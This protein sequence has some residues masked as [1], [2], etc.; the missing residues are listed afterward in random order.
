MDIETKALVQ[1]WILAFCEAPV[2][3]DAELMRR[4]LDDAEAAEERRKP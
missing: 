1:R 2:L 4:V 3:I